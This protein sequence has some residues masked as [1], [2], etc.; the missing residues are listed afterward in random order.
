MRKR[1]SHRSFNR[2]RR[3]KTSVVV[4]VLLQIGCAT[5]LVAAL[6][7]V[8]SVSGW[9]KGWTF[10]PAHVVPAAPPDP[11]TSLRP[12]YPYSVIPGGAYSPAELKAK[13]ASDETAARHYGSFHL[14][15]AKIVKAGSARPVYVSYRKGGSIYWTRRPIRLT[16]DE[17]LLTDGSQFARARCGN[18][19]SDTPQGPVAESLDSEPSPEM[20]DLPERWEFAPAEPLLLESK[21]PLPTWQEGPHDRNSGR[22]TLSAPNRTTSMR[23]NKL[24][25]PEAMWLPGANFPPSVGPSVVPPGGPGSLP[26]TEPPSVISGPPDPE[27]GPISTRPERP[28]EPRPG[29]PGTEPSPSVPPS[30]SAGPVPGAP[31][32]PGPDLP[33]LPPLTPPELAPP[34]PAT[35][36][37]NPTVPPVT[38]PA[39]PPG[40][41]ERPPDLE[42][43]ISSLPEPSSVLLALTAIGV[44]V[45]MHWWRRR[46]KRLP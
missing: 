30:S 23:N 25:A 4:S 43:P 31:P 6:M 28:H 46:A 14:A 40:G 39:E 33:P 22:N 1:G 20:L 32:P 38:P 45:G 3:Q 9:P 8:V 12:V 34:P 2:L 29:L 37:P 10:H 41:P 17:A 24:L 16:P 44:L 36:P 13:L 42:P 19:I 5:L 15:Q 11:K 7:R 35:E 21:T 26:D 27:T 18:R